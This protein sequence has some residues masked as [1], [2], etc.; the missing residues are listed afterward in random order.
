MAISTEAVKQLRE[1]TGAGILDCRNALQEAN[2][3]M[4][5]AAEILRAKGDAKSVKKSSRIAAEGIV[6]AYVHNGR[7]ASL[8]EVNTET[9]F[10][11]KNEEL[12]TFV[13]NLCLQV[14]SLAPEHVS[15]EEVP[16]ERLE[17]ERNFLTQQAMDEMDP[18]MPEEKR[19][20]IAEK[21]VEGRL[22][23]FFEDICLVDQKYIKDP[24]KTVEQV[25]QEL[26]SK[27]GENIVIRRFVRF[28]VGE[29]IEKKN[30]NFAE[31][32]AKQMKM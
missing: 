10:A 27:I 8:V 18:N 26:V 12:K 28:E 13:H 19:K 6:D 31:E 2:G 17:K 25:R 5:K 22:V 23:K 29:G 21:K 7:I 15:R 1:M 4:E 14:T 32:V 24:S 11:A 3:N 9:D 20:M 16:Q 30:E